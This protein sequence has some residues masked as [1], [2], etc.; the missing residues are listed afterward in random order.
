[1]SPKARL[2]I[3]SKQHRT[4]TESYLR[5]KSRELPLSLHI[6]GSACSSLHTLTCTA[7]SSP[8][9]IQEGKSEPKP[10]RKPTL[11]TSNGYATTGPLAI[12]GGVQC[13]KQV[14]STK[15]QDIQAGLDIALLLARSMS[16]GIF[17]PRDRN[18]RRLVARRA[19]LWL[20]PSL[21][22]LWVD[23]LWIMSWRIC[24]NGR[25]L[26]RPGL[27]GLMPGLIL[28]GLHNIDKYRQVGYI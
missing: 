13:K 17:G 26:T 6:P 14:S 27:W 18:S 12:T 24:C 25:L 21:R 9:D 19:V 4:S 1:M 11:R 22:C 10:K 28:R 23:W 5:L 20:L 2:N 15:R 16:M 3:S 7:Q 8:R